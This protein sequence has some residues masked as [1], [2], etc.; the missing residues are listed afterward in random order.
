MTDDT[1]IQ[2]VLDGAKLLIARRLRID[3]MKSGTDLGLRNRDASP[4]WGLI[5]A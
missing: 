3:P 4:A 2:Q 5:C 1:G